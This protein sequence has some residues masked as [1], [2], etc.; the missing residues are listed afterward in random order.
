VASFIRAVPIDSEM[1]KARSRRARKGW[2]TMGTLR[3]Q[4]DFVKLAADIARLARDFAVN[5]AALRDL[6]PTLA[7][8]AREIVHLPRDGSLSVPRAR[9]GNHG[10]SVVA[11]GAGVAADLGREIPRRGAGG[12]RRAGRAP[13]SDP[14]PRIAPA[15]SVSAG[16]LT[17]GPAAA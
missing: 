2:L 1:K 13:E 16:N 12:R 3:R 4:E 5:R 6:R 8:G 14:L 10:L 9:Q 7:G 15:L 11:G 17:G